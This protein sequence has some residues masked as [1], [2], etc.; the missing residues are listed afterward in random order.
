MKL[1]TDPPFCCTQYICRSRPDRITISY[2][3][4]RNDRFKINI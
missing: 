2:S 3:G 1:G 4:H